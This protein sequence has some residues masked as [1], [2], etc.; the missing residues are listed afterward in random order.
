[1]EPLNLFH[2]LHLQPVTFN[3]T[4]PDLIT[5][6]QKHDLGHLHIVAELWGVELQSNQFGEAAKELS[7]SLLDPNLLAETLDLLPADAKSALEA[8]IQKNG[9]I[10]WAR[11]IRQYGDI[12]EMGAGKRDREKPHRNP[13]SAAES[14]FYHALLARAF[15]DTPSG[16]QEFAYVPDDLFEIISR[17]GRTEKI[18][19]TAEVQNTDVKSEP[20]GRPASP[21]ERAH[22][23]PKNDR[24]LDNATTLL[25]ALR[26][27]I[28]P[29]E[30]SIP[31]PVLEGLLLSAKIISK[32]GPRPEAV[33]T[34]LEAPREKALHMLTEAWLESEAFNEL[35]QLPGL[36]FEGE[37]KNQPVVTRDFLL[38]LLDAIPEGQWWSLNAFVRKVKEKYPDF[39]RP[40]GDY[41]SWY[42]KR[43]DGEYLRGFAHWDEVDGALIRYF[44]TGILH[45]LGQVELAAPEEGAAPAAFKVLRVENQKVK[46]EDE[47]LHVNSQGKITV[48]RFAPRTVRYQVSRFCVWEG[49][50][51]DEYHYLLT[52]VSLAKAA[53]QGLKTEHLLALLNKHASGGVPP[54][55]VKALKRW[56][57]NG[58]EARI[59]AQVVLRVS[60]PEVLEAMRKSKAARFLG[61]TLGPTAVVVRDGAQS[62]VLSALAEMGLLAEDATVQGTKEHEEKN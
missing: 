2:F 27:G 39:Q 15:F 25:A 60:R 8:L 41:D 50:K 28:D 38:N 55:L 23:L 56:E 34:F 49:S 6:L 45:W 31:V 35:R 62:K 40:A 53:K 10:P 17:E 44:I 43:A 18:N 46:G 3:Q 51:K 22:P 32:S 13:A 48:P 26:L 37:W 29:P 57:V 9:R 20:L 59:Q 61:E 5:A 52:P 14:L 54:A 21:V 58:T 12:R 11:F 1:M 47:K 19:I 30:M 24:L 4:M 42:I 33:K 16:P 36:T 7:A